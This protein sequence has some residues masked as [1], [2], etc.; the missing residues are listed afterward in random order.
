MAV[1]DTG[2]R[3]VG[4]TEFYGGLSTDRKI[5][6]ENSFY[7][8]VSL[9]VRKSPSQMTVLPQSREIDD[10]NVITGLI[11]AMEQTKDGTIWG[12]DEK[13]KLYSIDAQNTITAIGSQ[14]ATSSGHGLIYFQHSDALWFADGGHSLFSYSKIIN[15]RNN[16]RSFHK[17]EN[18]EDYSQFIVNS[19]TRDYSGNYVA[20]TDVPRNDEG[21]YGN[22]NPTPVYYDYNCPQ[23]ISENEEDKILFL[24]GIDP[25][26]QVGIFV[27]TKGA[28]TLK[29]VIH[30]ANDNVVAESN[31]I[32]AANITEGD[33]TL[34]DVRPDPTSA[35]SV[36][37][38]TR[39]IP[40]AGETQ[41]AG[42]E[43]HIHIIASSAGYVLQTVTE[44]SLYFGGRFIANGSF[45]LETFNKKH[46][47]ALG[48][49]LYIGN[50]QYIAELQGPGLADSLDDTTYLPHRL[51][52]DDGFEVCAIGTSDEYIVIG[53]EKYSTSS[54]RGFQAGRL[55]FWDGTSD[56]PNFY[57][58][59][60]IGS[61]HCI[62]NYANITYIIMKGALYAYTGGKELIKVRT[63]KGTDNEFTG[64]NTITDVFPN[65]ITTR[66]EIM[67]MGFP[68]TTTSQRTR[69]GIWG[70]GSIDKNYP[71]CFT[72]NYTIP[73]AEEGQ[74]NTNT[75]NIRLGC[76]YNFGDSLFYGY[77]ITTYDSLGNP[78][79]KPALAT[80][81]NECGTATDFHW[82]SLSYDAGSPIL[83]KMGL[84]FGIYFDKLPAGTEIT[85]IYRIDE[86]DVFPVSSGNVETVEI[87]GETWCKGPHTA[88]EGDRSVLCEVNQRIHE[89]QYGFIGKTNN[90]MITPVIK[91]VA[92][93]VRINNE[94]RKL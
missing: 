75:Q 27:K 39:V 59:C 23:A 92:G 7:D 18:L 36:T 68:S 86:G 94:E 79:V 29:L 4:N 84:R 72:H 82:T 44:D 85:P 33:Y 9:D 81:D 63:L 30:D 38:Q 14:L 8:A 11:T 77:E 45:L 62:Y 25:I 22:S 54:E 58:D 1:G 56:I 47:M 65:M 10:N 42:E 67:L 49:S 17:F 61:P 60:N 73:G 57:I 88:V 50:G 31:E 55:Y 12:L 35:M 3:L 70:W 34:F 15:P 89:F 16:A 93:E 43:Y 76:V 41:L 80:V 46:P 5:G 19:I 40:W 69:F 26:T 48:L 6:I 71:N 2:S 32:S 78:V 21:T 64:E 13:G 53:A 52:I 87:N 74:F 66:R 90:G 51:K 83:E 20:N 91:Q 28:G 24:S 37:N